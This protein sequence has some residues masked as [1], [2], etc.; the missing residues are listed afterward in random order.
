MNKIAICQSILAGWGSTFFQGPQSSILQD[1]QVP[2]IAT[3]ECEQS[4]KTIFS[5][6]IFDNRIICAGNG[7]HD[8]CQGDSG[9]HICLLK[10]TQIYSFYFVSFD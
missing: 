7:D 2:I 10:I 3:A 5:M 1:T 4:Y 8:A 6:Q 9:L